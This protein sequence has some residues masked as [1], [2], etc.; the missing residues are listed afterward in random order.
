MLLTLLNKTYPKKTAMIVV[1]VSSSIWGVLWI[2]LRYIESFGLPGVWANTFFAAVSIPL[3]YGLS[4]QHLPKKEFW[5]T[6]G[7]AGLFVGLGFVC[8]T[9]GL[10]VGSVTKTTLL[11]YL[12]PVWASI[13]GLFFLGEKLKPILWLCN[14]TGLVGCALILGLDQDEMRFDQTD[15]LGFL[16]GIFWAIGSV[17]VSRNPKADFTAINFVVYIVVGMVGVSGAF[18]M[19]TPVPEASS[20]L[21]ATPVALIVS[22]GIFVPA[23][24]F[25]IR[26]QQYLSPSIVGILMLSEVLFAV[27]SA[28]I[29]LGETLGA[30]QWLGGAMIILAAVVVT[31]SQGHTS[32]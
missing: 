32:S 25:I 16:S 28:E 24:L 1:L 23:M 11:F 17:I 22:M 30:T 2:P 8:Y 6:Y 21:A 18:L 9:L 20:F 12:L 27:V 4:R 10:I 26:V 19:G 7:G 13:L 14:L 5:P 15:I 3:L 29:M 31:R